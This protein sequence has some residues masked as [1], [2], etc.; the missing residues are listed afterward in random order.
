MLV[1]GNGN[2]RFPYSLFIKEKIQ[3]SFVVII[4][5]QSMEPDYAN[6]QEQRVG[7]T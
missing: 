5:S 4:R 1:T 6:S 3:G 7:I 2:D